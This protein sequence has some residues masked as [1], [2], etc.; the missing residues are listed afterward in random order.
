MCW[1]GREGRK[2]CRKWWL[3]QIFLEVWRKR[4]EG[5]NSRQITLKKGLLTLCQEVLGQ[6]GIQVLSHP[7][8]ACSPWELLAE[9]ISRYRESQQKELW[10]PEGTTVIWALQ[11]TSIQHCFFVLRLPLKPDL[12]IFEIRRGF[13]ISCF[14]WR[15][16]VTVHCQLDR[17]LKH[18]DD[19]PLSGKAYKGVSKLG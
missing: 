7:S 2:E 6:N 16:T 9:G 1:E 12:N 5:L 3:F 13:A 18:L 11:S 15:V 14:L 19:R 17:I 4:K 10:Q 8:R